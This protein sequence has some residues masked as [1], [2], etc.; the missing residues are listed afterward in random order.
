MGT[1]IPRPGLVEHFRLAA[2]V[3]DLAWCLD[4]ICGRYGPVVDVGFRIPIRVIYV[5]GP[6]ANQYI[7]SDH[8]ENFLWGE[9]LRLLKVITGPT[10]LVLSDGD[11]HKRRRRLVQPAFGVKRIEAQLGL[12]VNEID[13]VLDTWTPGRRLDAF[14]ALRDAARRVAVRSLFGE[15]MGQLADHLGETLEPGLDYA[16]RTP[17]SRIDVNLPFLPYGKAVRAREEADEIV[18]GEVRRRR[19]EGIDAD[20]SPD[21]LSALLAATEEIDG[22]ERPLSDEEICD[23]V[24]SL[25][26]AGYDTTSSAMS[27]IVHALGANPRVLDALRTQVRDTIGDRAPTIDDLRSMP[28]VDGVV[29]ETL[30]LW[31]PGVASG[32]IAVDDF[33][34]HGYTIPGGSLVMY[35]PYIT[36]RL[37]EVWGDPEVF[38]PERWEAGEPVPFSYV[39]FGGAY[40]KCIGFALATL[41]LQ[42]LT[43]RLAQCVTWELENPDARGAGI[44]NFAP[45]GGVP[46]QVGP[47]PRADSFA[48]EK[49]QRR[50]NQGGDAGADRNDATTRG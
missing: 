35:S 4:R 31:P 43:V 3:N 49:R 27:W 44:A 36:H 28:L 11:E 45:K 16:S 17:M 29:R 12:V 33:E 30:R 48:R 2:K 38:R 23:Q 25:I 42:V 37:P 40:R 15:D 1:D 18:L 24:R 34:L 41:E 50:P 9:A 19:A 47:A 5:S 14:P 13:R 21:T 8:P 26:A 10:A 6:Q 7:L 39:P 20:A 46:I 32:R 22:D